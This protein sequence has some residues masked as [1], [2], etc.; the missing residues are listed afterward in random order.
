V[1]IQTITRRSA[2]T[3]LVVSVVG[4]VAGFAF[5]RNSSANKRTVAG[6]GA[7]S[8]GSAPA[9]GGTVLATVSQ[10]PTGGGIILGSKKIVLTRGPDGVVHGFSAICTHQ[11]CTVNQ[12]SGG[13]IDCP[14]HGS[15]FN[16]FTGAVVNGPATRPLPQAPIVVRGNDVVSA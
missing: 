10:L 15:R 8:Y 1:S 6:T 11:G 13:T 5:A 7:N 3:G 16:A 9:S 12:V 2:F 14:C 4:A